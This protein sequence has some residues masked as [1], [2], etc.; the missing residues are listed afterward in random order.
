MTLK[1]EVTRINYLEIKFKVYWDEIYSKWIHIILIKKVNLLAMLYIKPANEENENTNINNK[2]L[3]SI[4]RHSPESLSWQAPPPPKKKRGAP[5]VVFNFFQVAFGPLRYV[6][7]HLLASTTI[8]Y[9][10]KENLYCCSRY[11]KYG[12]ETNPDLIY[13]RYS[14]YDRV[15][16]HRYVNWSVS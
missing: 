10:C 8:K 6:E 12:R 14:L 1:V 13:Y 16:F 7:K 9:I 2:L 11:C 4:R 15:L 3:H 5:T